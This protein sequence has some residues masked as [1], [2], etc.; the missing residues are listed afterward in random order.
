MKVMFFWWHHI[1]RSFVISFDL[2]D[3]VP[4][5]WFKYTTS[6]VCVLGRFYC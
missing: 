3:T 1:H 6:V 5:M 4:P 2:G